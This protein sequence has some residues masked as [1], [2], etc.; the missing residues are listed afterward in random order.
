M[1]YCT[2]YAQ[3]FEKWLIVSGRF[4][5]CIAIN[6]LI[7]IGSTLKYKCNMAITPKSIINHQFFVKKPPFFLFTTIKT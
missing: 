5:V 1:Y 2:V 3:S 6:N 7:L 4:L